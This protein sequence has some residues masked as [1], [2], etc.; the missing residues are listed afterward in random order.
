[1]NV[2]KPRAPAILLAVVL[3]AQS[4]CREPREEGLVPFMFHVFEAGHESMLGD[5]YAGDLKDQLNENMAWTAPSYFWDQIEPSDD[6]FHWRELDGFVAENGDKHR[7]INLGPE[8]VPDESGE[9]IV[10]GSLPPWLDNRL[11]NPTLKGQYGEL[12]Q[13]IVSRY[14]ERIDMWW[15]GLEVN[16]G[17]DGLSWQAW[18][19][20]LR[21]QVSLIREKDPSTKIAISFGSWTGYHERIPPN[22]VHEIVGAQ[23][24]VEEGLDF[25]VIAMEYHHGTLQDGDL[26]GMRRSLDQLERLGK[27][28]FLWE[29]FYPAETDVRYHH[30]WSWDSPPEAGYSEEWQAEQWLGTLKLAVEDPRI[31]GINV[32]HFQD[33]DHDLIDPTQWEAGWRCHAG[34]V[35]HDGTPREAYFRIRNYWSE[36]RSLR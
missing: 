31:I 9:L 13:A 14:A 4:G 21:W 35:R 10:L 36:V 22:A 25:D 29:V 6:R 11:S 33:L 3:L 5:D 18:K 26:S 32:H 23:G 7:V 17:G 27:E 2:R 1:M 16:L 24:L 15:I 30:F 8:I 28:I 20:W 12:L 34:L 19:E